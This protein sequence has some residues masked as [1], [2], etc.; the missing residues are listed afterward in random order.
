MASH[1]TTSS[2]AP[3]DLSRW[4][5]LPVVA[6]VAGLVFLTLGAVVAG[7]HGSEG[8]FRQFGFSWLLAFMFFLSLCLGGLFLVL[9]HHLF[10]ASWSVPIRRYCEHLACLSL[11]LAVLFIPIA[12]LA[13]RIYPWMSMKVQDHALHAKAAMLNPTFFYIRI[14]AYFIIWIVLSHSLRRFSVAQDKDGAAAWTNRMR[15]ASYLGIFLFAIT[16]TFAAIDWMKSL[17]HQWFS[18]MY[19]VWYFAGSVWTTLAT[20]Y[21]I[22]V[23]LKRTGSLKDALFPTHFYYIGSLLFAFTVFY[24]YITFSQYFIIWNAN[25]PEETFWYRLREVGTWRWVGYV[26]IFGHFFVPFLTLLRIDVKLKLTIMLP[27]AVWAWLMHFFDLS[28]N[29]MPTL[30]PENFVLHWMD[31]GAFLLIGGILTI[32]FLRSLGTTAAYPLRDPRLKESLTSHE[33][34]AEADSGFVH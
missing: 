16:L 29:I 2:A 11:P 6:I 22:A 15:V 12:L 10:D 28:F 20:V 34:P 21:V 18:T 4:R 19:G 23:V 25:M 3:L 31:I 32:L 7:R 13:H 30:H 8:L 5:K 14:V 26:I 17:H 1:N 9:A 24:A 27:I 33:L